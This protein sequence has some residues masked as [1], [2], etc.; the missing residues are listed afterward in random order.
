MAVRALRGAMRAA[1]FTDYGEPLAVGEI[2]DPEPGPDGVV[3]EVEACGVCR[4][5]WHA[6]RGDWS[7]AFEPG[8]VFGHEPAGHVVEVG[9]DVATVTEGEHVTVPFHLADGTCGQCRNGRSNLCEHWVS[10][11]LRPG[12]MGAFAE[13]LAVPNADVNAVTLPDGVSS[14]DV[15]G[16]G[17]RFMTAFHALVHRADVG[18]GDWVAVHGCGGVGQSAVHV[19]DAL[20]ASVVGVD[21]DDGTLDRAAALGAAETVNATRTAAPTSPW[22]RWASPKRVSTP[23]GASE[24]GVPTSR[25]G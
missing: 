8:H 13:R 5:D 19:A 3:V 18:G 6:W 10:L 7:A 11:G 22:T 4:S 23:C 20:G 12:S 14:V 1:T 21:V 24:S 17:C 15:A 16:L 2:D 9:E 25:S